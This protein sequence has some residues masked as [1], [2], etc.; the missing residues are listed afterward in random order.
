MSIFITTYERS[1][2]K[3]KAD[4]LKSVGE[5]KPDPLVQVLRRLD[6]LERAVINHP[7]QFTVGH[8]TQAIVTHDDITGLE[9]DE[10]INAIKAQMGFGRKLDSQNLDAM[11]GSGETYYPLIRGIQDVPTQGDPVLLCEFGG[12]KYYMGPLNVFGQSNFNPD[13]GFKLDQS[14]HLVQESKQDVTIKQQHN[15]NP[16][17]SWAPK[18]KRLMKPITE[19]SYLLKDNASPY[20]RGVGDLMLEGRF[21]NSIRIGSRSSTPNIVISNGR[22][23][24]QRYETLND[25]S[26]LCMLSKGSLKQH[27]S[28]TVKQKVAEVNPVL[29]SNQDNK[30]NR[31]ITF[32]NETLDIAN[33]NKN[34]TVLMSDR[35]LFQ[36]RKDDIILSS[37]KN[38]HIGGSIF[39]I[40]TQGNVNVNSKKLIL[41]DPDNAQEA[42]V[43]GDQLVSVLQELIKAIGSCYVNG[44]QPAGIS[45]AIGIAGSPGWSQL[46]KLYGNLTK[47]KSQ[48]ATVATKPGQK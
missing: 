21:G 43:L 9:K 35:L 2:I 36:S 6:S 47:I 34:Q 20:N 12:R 13:P 11:V 30:S 32:E 26:I 14:E 27:F 5:L 1:D 19:S 17:F 15:V 48:Y 18:I 42:L 38:I 23:D 37:K 33:Y 24:D 28:F 44:V 4:S 8:C 40:N 41:G 31:K 10:T 46:Q 29:V 22:N 45:G 3:D 25:G 7:I 39:N 16:R